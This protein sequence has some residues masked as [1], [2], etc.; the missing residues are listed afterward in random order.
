MTRRGASH[1]YALLPLCAALAAREASAGVEVRP[2]VELR[3]S[4]AHDLSAPLTLM[5]PAE[6]AAHVEHEP[7][8]FRRFPPSADSAAPAA[9]SAPAGPASA[10]AVPGLPPATLARP[11]S[12]AQIA[13]LGAT[14]FRG[15]GDG[16]SSP[17][18]TFSVRSHPS[19]A[20]GDIG[21]RHYVQIVNDSIAVFDRR[22]ALLYGEVPTNTLWTG[23]DTHSFAYD[24]FNDYGKFGVW[25]DAYYAT[26]NLFVDANPGSAY[27]GAA[28]CAFDRKS[29]LAGNPASQQCF[30]LFQVDAAV[31]PA[32]LYGGLLPADLDGAL[33]PPAGA[34]NPMMSFDGGG[35]LQV[36]KFHADWADPSRS[37]LNGSATCTTSAASCAPILI[38]VNSFSLLCFTGASNGTCIPQKGVTQQLDSLADRPMFRLAY[39]N[40]G[41]HESLLL[42]HSVQAGAGGGVR[43]YELRDLTSPTGPTL[44]QQGTFAPD[45]NFRWMGSLAM[46][47]AGDIALAYSLSG[48]QL[49]PGIAYT[50]R[51]GGDP[52]G[53][54]TLA[55][56]SLQNGAGPQGATPFKGSNRWGDYSSMSIDPLDDCTFWYTAEYMPATGNWSTA[57]ASFQLSS[58]GAFRV[59]APS[60]GAVTRGGGSTALGVSVDTSTGATGTVSL[61]AGGLPTGVTATFS[62]SSLAVPGTSTLTLAAD[63]STTQTLRAVP[64]RVV[65]ALQGTTQTRSAALSLDVLGNEFG[66]TAA[67]QLTLVPAGAARTIDVRTKPVSGVAESIALSTGPLP[68]GLT[69]AFNPAAVIAGGGSTLTLAGGAAQADQQLKLVM[70]GVAPSSSHDV[71]LDVQTLLLPIPSLLAPAAGARLTGGVD[72]SMAASVSPSTTLAKLELLADGQP[73]AQA[74]VPG[75]LR[76]DTTRL[77]NG[78]RQFSVRATDAASGV[79]LSAPVA[80]TVDNPSKGCGCAGAGGSLDLSALCLLPLVLWFS[81]RRSTPLG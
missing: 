64:V 32:P 10:A 49:Y 20:V 55:E 71:F 62:P 9:A 76:L 23:F 65:A 30:K 5:P 28:V 58:C 6:Q 24:A 72:F 36:W 11:G 66:L 4:V 38:A 25:P 67:P 41:D 50:A 34:P 46:D 27:L 29:M 61:S 3:S 37:T 43:W 26:Y 42:N 75:F 13:T 14:V 2:G 48:A 51:A 56:T 7:R 79:G 22:G 47:A 80:M 17:N 57:I 54:M 35:N 45:A 31:P 73:V 70:H 1:L 63:A 12:Q 53:A 78:T 19:D 69:A 21:P 8:P 60:V 74:S 16:F 59:T 18:G 44:Y 33:P 39:R 40:F 77:G 68:P 81:R 52:A 15:L